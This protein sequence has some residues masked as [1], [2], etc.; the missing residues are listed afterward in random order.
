MQ[1][2]LRN[3]R[4]TYEVIRDDDRLL[5]LKCVVFIQRE[6]LGDLIFCNNLDQEIWMAKFHTDRYVKVDQIRDIIKTE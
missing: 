3:G 1:L 6:D 2:K 5:K 4:N